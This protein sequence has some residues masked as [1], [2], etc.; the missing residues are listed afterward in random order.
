MKKPCDCCQGP[1]TL[2]GST[3]NPPGQGGI[4]CRVATYG[5]FLQT[6]QAKLSGRCAGALEGLR[7][8]EK[9]DWSM[10]L[11]DAWSTV[12]DVLTFYQ[13]RIAN[14]GYLRTA[15]ERRSV[16]ELARL[17]GYS[18]RPGVAASAY[19]SYTV[20]KSSGPVEVPAGAKANTIPGPGEQMQTFETSEPLTARYEWNAMRPRLTHAQTIESIKVKGLY[21]K[22][23]ATNLKPNDPLIITDE[24]GPKLWWIDSLTPDSV[25]DRTQIVVRP[26]GQTAVKASG[27]AAAA[28]SAPQSKA[29]VRHLI[30]K[31]EVPPSIPPASANALARDVGS[32]FSARADAVP[33]LLEVFRPTLGGSFYA[34][35][36]NLPA[37]PTPLHVYA[38]RVAAAP[39]G[40]NAPPRLTDTSGTVPKFGEW[41]TN[42]PLGSEE[43]VVLAEGRARE[44]SPRY[45]MPQSL[46]LDGDYDIAFDGRRDNYVVV[47]KAGAPEVLKFNGVAHVSLAAYGLSGKSTLLDLADRKP[48]LNSATDFSEVRNS[49]IFVGAQELDLAEAPLSGD[50]TGDTVELG[51][52][53]GGLDPGRWL[54]VSGERSD[55]KAD[56]QAVPG[57]TAAELVMLAAVEQR[58]KRRKGAA[59]PGETPHSFLR[60]ATPLAY[61]YKR[62][63]VIVHGNVAHAT[64]GETRDE[65]LGGGDASR[66]FQTFS[67]KQPPL[68]YVSASSDSGIQT[69]L[70]VRVNEVKWREAQ[71]LVSLSPA[72][73][74]FI[75]R[76]EDEGKTTVVTGNGEHGARLP[77]GREN[78]IARY[79]NGIGNG[80]NV[81]A[82]QISLLNTRPLGIKEVVN[83]IRASGGADR[84]TRDQARKRAPLSVAALDRLLADQDYA[85]FTLQFGGIGKAA[86]AR[87][88]HG[89]HQVVHVTIAGV[90]DAPIETSSDVYRNL[91]RALHRYGDPAVSIALAPRERLAL[92]VSANVRIDSD[93]RWDL[94]EP[95][96]RAAMLEEFCFEHAE[97]GRDLLMSDAACVTQRVPGVVYVDIDVFDVVSETRLMTG[98]SKSVGK[99]LTA[100][101][102]VSVAPAE[103]GHGDTIRPAQI[104]YLTA[105]VPETL[106]LRE[107]KP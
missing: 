65:V 17:V 55:I 58:V 21:V 68:T 81:K 11:L 93:H 23:I 104:A 87:L 54:I 46:Y 84:E 18:P 47:L 43:T 41:K 20:E 97:L 32:S 12:G 27:A 8:R 34:A 35:W 107:L 48:W 78:V 29:L 72:D 102:R 100:N 98:L 3:V 74:A 40:H 101:E 69:T 28:W 38:L 45:H 76:T 95:K 66:T 53:Y 85:D 10:A 82:G 4:S 5:T 16:L 92:I 62:D 13:E 14:E 89:R 19:L 37:A 105:D 59:L 36:K 15:T 91:F 30:R 88:V 103:V 7:T 25:N 9:S 94:V 106:I 79:R 56:D 26:A 52:L 99:G 22:G 83:P 64:H 61:R 67:L 57:V 6:M 50:V 24:D 1:R 70:E 90:E 2:A 42:Q 51:D 33:R 63:T 86:S 75:T 44:A 49:R 96:I 73:Q 80:G 60:L 39:F 77:T 71:A 31:L